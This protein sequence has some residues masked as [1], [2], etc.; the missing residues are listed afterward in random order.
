MNSAANGKVYRRTPFKKIYCPA[1]AGDAGG[2]IGAAVLV[3]SQLDKIGE[4]R[5]S[6]LEDGD[7]QLL[8]SIY[9]LRSKRSLISAYLGP[10]ATDKE[11]LG[12]ID[13]KRKETGDAGCAILLIKDE[14]QLLCKTA[15]AD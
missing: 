3:Q 6:K 1:A 11:L 12:L 9:D 10:E 7:S 14:E 15:H 13:R 5:S 2:A 4:V 8:S